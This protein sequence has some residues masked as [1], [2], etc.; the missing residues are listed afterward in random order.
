MRAILIN[1]FDRQVTEIEIP[2]SRGGGRYKAMYDALG[3]PG[4]PV[5]ETFPDDPE[6]WEPAGLERSKMEVST[7]DIQGI[8]P[9]VDLWI[10]DNGR[11]TDRQ[12]CFKFKRGPDV[13]WAGRCIILSSDEGGNT[14]DA[15][16]WLTVEQVKSKIEWLPYSFDYTPPPPLILFGDDATDMLCNHGGLNR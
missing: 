5:D 16:D 14:I 13:P 10:D 12:A 3:G 6:I 8:G 15:P 2:K 9:G 1:P 7:F 4:L 11:I